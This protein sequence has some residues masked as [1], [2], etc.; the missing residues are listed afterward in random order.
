MDIATE[1]VSVGCDW[2][3]VTT[4]EPETTGQL[5]EEAALLM[6][7]RVEMGFKHQGWGMAGFS[8]FSTSGVQFGVRNHEGIVRLSSDVAHTEWRKFY[9]MAESVT[10]FD[11]ECTTRCK[12]LA[13][14]RVR[15]SWQK[16]TRAV[17]G[18]AGAPT[19][20]L[21]TSNRGGSTVYL[22]SRSSIAF[23]RIYDKGCETPTDYFRNCVRHEV[24]MKKV[25]AARVAAS[26]Y[27]TRT[28][29][30][31]SL[32]ILQGF[33]SNRH[34]P[35]SFTGPGKF[36]RTRRTAPTDFAALEWLRNQVQPTVKRLILCG[37]GQLVADSLGL[38][39]NLE[40]AR[41]K[42]VPLKLAG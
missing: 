21:I 5:L 37:M 17:R 26:L 25:L 32:R 6:H 15:R 22:G 3:T 2:I 9:E 41:S 31:E 30:D 27:S 11:V 39:D 19:V 10:R 24:E 14:K 13:A 33:F 8:G 18:K 38:Y 16:A 7:S 4:K 23:G 42:P 34:C 29:E 28:P 20:T 12:C 40:L 1:L 36:Y 35:L